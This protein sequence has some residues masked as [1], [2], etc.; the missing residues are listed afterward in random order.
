MKM[1]INCKQLFLLQ[2]IVFAI[3]SPVFAQHKSCFTENKAQW[4]SQVLYKCDLVYGALFLEKNCFTFSFYNPDDVHHSHEP[5]ELTNKRE[6]S[7]PT[8]GIVRHHA[9][10]VRFINA[11]E[12]V[13]VSANAPLD[14]YSN[15]FIGNDKTKW[16]NG[17][18]SF[19][20]V[21]Y[22]GI[23][24]SINMVVNTNGD[25]IVYDFIVEKGGD[26]GQIQI[27]YKGIDDI[28]LHGNEL[29]IKTSVNQIT[30]LKPRAYQI[31]GADT[32]EVVCLFVLKNKTL[33]FDFPNGYNHNLPLIIDPE[34]VFATYSGS[35]A[36]N[37]G[38]TATNDNEGNVYSGGIVHGTGYPV[39]TGAFQ[40]NY[41]GSW[42]IGII[43]YNPL[44]TQRLY[45][46]YLGG[47][48]SEMPHSLIVNEF[49]ELLILGTTGSLNFPVTPKAYDTSFNGGT[50]LDYM[51]VDFANGLDLYVAKLSPDGSQLMASTYIGGSANDGLNYRSGYS[52]YNGNGILYYN[53]GDGARGEII[54]D[55]QNDVYIGTCTFSNNFPVTSNGFQLNNAGNQDGVVFKLDY[56]LGTL[57]WS[58][59]IGGSNDDAAY[60]IDVDS[61]YNLFIAGGTN[62]ID[63]PSDTTG[64]KPVRP[65]GVADAFVAKVSR[66]GRK[67]MNATFF[68]STEYDQAYFVRTDK[69]DEVY[70]FGQTKAKDSTLIHNAPYSKANSGQFLARFSHNL[71]S[72]VW[73]TVFGTGNGKPNISPTAFAVDICDRIYIAGSGRE[74]TTWQ[75]WK[76]KPGVPDT[77]YYDFGWSL[78]EGTKGMEI[79]PNAYQKV[80]DGQDFYIAVFDEN[81]TGLD[82]ATFFGELFYGQCERNETAGGCTGCIYSGRDH[83]DGGTSRF[84]KRG[85]IY[86]SVC[87]S[88]GGCQGIPTKPNPGAW[89][90]TNKSSNCNNAVFR[91]NLLND[92]TIADFEIPPV[93]CLPY[94][95]N[96]MNN[97]NSEKYFWD[98]GDG[99]TSTEA[100]PKHEYEKPGFYVVTLIAY[101]SESCNRTDT[102]RRKVQIFSNSVDTLPDLTVCEGSRVQLGLPPNPSKDITYHWT[103]TANISDPNISNPYSSTRVNSQYLLTVSNGICF[104]SLYQKVKVVRN[105]FTV[106]ITGNLPIANKSI[107]ICK[108]DSLFL[109]ATTETDSIIEYIWADNLD[110]SKPIK[111]S[112][113]DAQLTVKPLKTTTYFVKIRSSFCDASGIDSIR[114]VVVSP[115]IALNDTVICEGDTLTIRALN[116]N[117]TDVLTYQWA[118]HEGDL[119]GE[120][121]DSLTVSLLDSQTFYLKTEN[122]NSCKAQDSIFVKVDKLRLQTQIDKIA[123][124]SSCDAAVSFMINGVEPYTVKVDGNLASA[125]TGNLCEGI[126]QVEV[127]DFAGCRI[128]DQ[129]SIDEAPA[130]FINLVDTVHNL[131]FGDSLGSAIVQTSGGLEPFHYHW[132]DSQ[133][134]AKA[135]NLKANVYVA[136]VIDSNQCSDSV[137][138][139]I[140]QPEQIIITI[141]SITQ[142]SCFGYCD[143]SIKASVT[144]GVGNYTYSWNS[145]PSQSTLEAIGLCAKT[146]QLTVT[147]SNHCSVI[148]SVIVEQP[149]SISISVV[150]NGELICSYDTLSLILTAYD[151]FGEYSF[152]ID[153]QNL[154]GN[155][156]SGVTA[157]FHTIIATDEHNCQNSTSYLV[158]APLPV[159]VDVTGST[160]AR[161]YESCDASL[162]VSASG[163]TLPYNYRWNTN[164]PQFGDSATNICSSTILTVTDRANC[165]FT[166]NITSAHPEPITTT[167]QQR[168]TIMCHGGFSSVL[169]SSQGGNGVY[170]YFLNGTQ[171]QKNIATGLYAGNYQVIT[172]DQKSCSDTL[173]FRI[174]EPD[175]LILNINPI[176]PASCF[177]VC[178]GV[179]TVDLTGGS[180]SYQ[181]VWNN[182]TTNNT[183]KTGLC[184]GYNKIK[185]TDKN[186]CT[187]TDSVFIQ[188]PDSIF[189]QISTLNPLLCYGDTTTAI[190]AISGGTSSYRLWWDDI[191]EHDTVYHGIGAGNHHLIVVD[192]HNCIDTTSFT[193]DQPEKLAANLLNKTDATCSGFC[194][195]KAEIIASGGVKPYNFT[196]GDSQTGEKRTDLCSS[197]YTVN[198]TDANNCTSILTFNIGM[199]SDL[200]VAISDLV[201]ASCYGYCNGSATVD[202]TGGS[203]T[204][205]VDWHTNPPQFGGTAVNLCAGNFQVTVKDRNNCISATNVLITQPDS[206][207][208]ITSIEKPVVCYGGEATLLAVAEGGTSPYQFKFSGQ[209]F[210]GNSVKYQ[211][212]AG[213]YSLTLSDDHLCTATS[214]LTITQPKEIVLD[215]LLKP[216]TCEEVCDGQITVFATGGV[217]P[218][219]FLWNVPDARQQNLLDSLCAGNYELKFIDNL[220]CTVIRPYTITVSGYIPPVDAVALPQTI[221]RLKNAQLQASPTDY[222]KYQWTPITNLSNPNSP[223][224]IA[225]PLQTTTYTVRITDWH[226]CTNTDT[227]TVYVRDV[228]CD[229][230]YIFVPNAFTPD[231]PSLGNHI[232][233]VRSN[234]INQLY[235]SVFDRWGE[236]VFETN[237]L[238][239]GWDGTFRGKKLAPDVFVYYLEA[240]CINQ[241]KFKKEGNINLIR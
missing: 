212:K 85:N 30:E 119:I 198:V 191:N 8:P 47:A 223:A 9:F 3:A 214:T 26:A 49:D 194:D 189:A 227:V 210:T 170:T 94:T 183:T 187:V 138:V 237:D 15:Y 22:H 196:W 16:S 91:I 32:I 46:T 25:N 100:N 148:K 12:S 80:T 185:V 155:I 39:S 197:N 73:S 229:E 51:G 131:C 82:Y 107:Q 1:N 169:L 142:P 78:I 126:H 224:P 96:F 53:Y 129:F 114:I 37:W 63:F 7:E 93:A 124:Y 31:D 154:T 54:T 164:P 60:S 29:V 103:P 102:L 48:S 153:S 125:N 162:K 150:E 220:G 13:Q 79:T 72:L 174:E 77:E 200:K 190:A 117:P 141:D 74:W 75:G 216:Q 118:T 199:P 92:F 225:N 42:D 137:E 144:G 236:K 209:T 240:T 234:V 11:L 97:S 139:I 67:L 171:L 40:Q 81:V 106:K 58:T 36:D 20:T 173:N 50:S 56:N 122:Q 133:T 10:K 238:N 172:R 226:G 135:I 208:I 43:K 136:T 233:L 90:N 45:A 161:C 230:P 219:Q 110:F 202:I 132:S 18:K 34:L 95:F 108:G 6:H 130:L 160:I 158:K 111:V 28:R 127:I 4:D 218:Y 83:V 192:A 109:D 180:P 140:K 179:A 19:S 89:S 228:I 222:T 205:F 101:N 52:A 176:S 145:D 149:D 23:Y 184:A 104:D 193:I 113:T 157:G 235:F 112:A 201:N 215:E 105:P 217:E 70:I 207:K 116:L 66:D 188:Q 166:F 168:S 152:S 87:G 38:F 232:L 41:N 84:D 167:S 231:D 88:C 221:Y 71:D 151:G 27:D 239:T 33:R 241:Q 69:H 24:R 65:G 57:V 14:G 123:C 182:V 59:Y 2:L 213:E 76:P 147:D 175:K 186:G 181:V 64:Y 98:F 195:G 55:D 128:S 61:K 203:P 165:I 146:Y 143:G 204:Y 115:Q 211:L 163:G 5:P 99:T 62:S 206:L 35:T 121:T 17:V 134:T 21:E 86:Q 159:S 44:G 68:G 178:D 156:A 120:N 177:G